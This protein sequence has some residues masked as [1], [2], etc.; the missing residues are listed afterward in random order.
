MKKIL[1]FLLVLTLAIVAV[2]PFTV[3]TF[4]EERFTVP[5]FESMLS[6][7]NVEIRYEENIGFYLAVEIPYGLEFIVLGDSDLTLELEELVGAH[8][9]A[10]SAMSMSG[11]FQNPTQ[12]ISRVCAIRGRYVHGVWWGGLIPGAGLVDS[13]G[14]ASIAHSINSQSIARVRPGTF[15]SYQDNGWRTTGNRS[16]ILLTTGISGNRAT[17]DLAGN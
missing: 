9:R 16:C 10:F 5:D 7:D 1:S 8:Y 17:W 6:S 13:V 2:L 14:S 3:S 12:Y 11:S 4:A 15:A